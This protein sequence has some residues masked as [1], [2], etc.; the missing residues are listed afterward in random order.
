[1]LTDSVEYIT[2]SAPATERMIMMNRS[3]KQ[4]SQLIIKVSACL[5]N[6]MKMITAYTE[7]ELMK[8]YLTAAECQR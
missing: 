6:M 5:T 1:M 4:V 7:E 3:V 8:E 2:D